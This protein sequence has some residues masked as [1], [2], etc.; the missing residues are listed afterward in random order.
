MRWILFLAMAALITGCRI[1]PSQSDRTKIVAAFEVPLSSEADR[2]QF[3]YVL[4]TAAEAERMRVDA[5]S[6]QELE[7]MAKAMPQTAMTMH[8]AVWRESTHDDSVALAMDQHDHLGEVWIMFFKSE[9]PKLA[10]KFRMRAMRVIMSRWPG[11]LSLP[12]MP[13]GSIPLHRDLVRTPK[14]YIVDPAAARK[15]DKEGAENQPH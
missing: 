10:D 3:L 14:G 6:S 9:D 1:A 8:A 11:T 4:R 5:D 12:I 13:T 2:D 15:Y 7:S